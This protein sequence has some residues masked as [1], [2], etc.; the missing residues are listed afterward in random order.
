M[1]AYDESNPAFSFN[2]KW[3][4]EYND[5]DVAEL[6]RAYNESGDDWNRNFITL[7][8]GTA[9]GPFD[10]QTV[11]VRRGDAEAL[12]EEWESLREFYS[13]KTWDQEDFEDGNE[14]VK[15]GP[16]DIGPIE[17]AFFICA[18]D[19]L[20]LDEPYT[21]PGWEDTFPI[22]DAWNFLWN[23]WEDDKRKQVWDRFKKDYKSAYDQV[24]AA[25][26]EPAPEGQRYFYYDRTD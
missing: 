14:L 10:C 20:Q 2:S 5:A 4:N 26:V 19:N 8:V 23:C 12:K 1:T 11:C 3:P 15:G 17:N 22:T 16:R 18:D 6:F 9:D 25:T 21:K 7:M 24:A 13:G